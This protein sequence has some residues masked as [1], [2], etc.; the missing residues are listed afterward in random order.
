MRS[1]P[2]DGSSISPAG[3]VATSR[4]TRPTRSVLSQANRV[5]RVDDIVAAGGTGHYEV[6]SFD[7]FAIFW[8]ST[9]DPVDVGQ[10]ELWLPHLDFEPES[11]LCR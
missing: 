1:Q 10:A 7:S 9:K 4:P 6:L 3:S 8:P 5:E 2:V 11:L